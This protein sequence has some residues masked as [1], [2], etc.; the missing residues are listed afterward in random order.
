[1]DVKPAGAG[2]LQAILPGLRV[3][4]CAVV[5]PAGFRVDGS[6]GVKPT[7]IQVCESS[8]GGVHLVKLSR[9]CGVLIV[10]LAPE[11]LQGLERGRTLHRKDIMAYT[12]GSTH[13]IA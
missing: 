12:P 5:T 11:V 6:S 3:F 10:Q 4:K 2:L 1:M 13:R 9:D 7:R 8:R